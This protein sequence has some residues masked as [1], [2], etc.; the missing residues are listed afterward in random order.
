MT[1]KEMFSTLISIIE[2]TDIENRTDL[3]EGLQHE[4]D[5]LDRK[6][7]TPKKPS[8]TQVENETFK[9]LILNY[10]SAVDAPVCIKEI[11]A[12]V[13]EVAEISNQRI[14]HILTALVNSEQ[15]IKS[16]IKKT[17]YYIIAQ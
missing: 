15:I 14:T 3:I 4:I 5:L 16:Y 11:Q 7:S 6:A 1:K 12:N 8:A 10:L 13:P 9:V 17:P 2:C